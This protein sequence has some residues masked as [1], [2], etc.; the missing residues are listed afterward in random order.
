VV[1]KFSKNPR[2]HSN[3]AIGSNSKIHTEIGS[4]SF[5][6]F[7]ST[8]SATPA[9]SLFSTASEYERPTATMRLSSSDK[10]IQLSRGADFSASNRGSFMFGA[11]LNQPGQI[12]ESNG[13]LRRRCHSFARLPGVDI[14]R[15]SALVLCLTLSC[16]ASGQTIPGNFAADSVVVVKSERSLKLMSQGKV[17]KTYKVALGRDPVGPKSRQGD[18][19][20]PEGAYVLDHRNAHSHFYRSIHIS[21]PNA[22]DAAQAKKLGIS[23]G[24]DVYVHG[25]P[26]GYGWAGSSHR[27]KDWTDGCIAVTNQEMDEIWR[28]VRD[29]TPIAIKP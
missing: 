22:R 9:I 8:G 3:A 24:G 13:P 25:L 11:Y 20:T 2:I 7:T 14:P 26:N 28:A 15:P 10:A 17:L 12:N 19:K 27:L 1:L 23:P 16:L 6:V 21:Y 5:G 29:G 4:H 18:H